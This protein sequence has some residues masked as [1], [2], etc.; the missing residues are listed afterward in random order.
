[1]VKESVQSKTPRYKSSKASLPLPEAGG[2]E[3]GGTYVKEKGGPK[4]SR[5][6]KSL[7]IHGQ[8]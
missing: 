4:E 8:E 6:N 5:H 2:G 7:R 1:M 3:G